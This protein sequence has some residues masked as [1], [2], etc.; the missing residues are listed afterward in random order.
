M[1]HEKKE[2]FEIKT[3]E[4]KNDEDISTGGRALTWMK[5]FLCF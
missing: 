4:E 5:D 1:L 2:R 3:Y